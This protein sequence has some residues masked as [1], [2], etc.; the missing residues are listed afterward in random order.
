[1]IRDAVVLAAGEGRRL[2]PLTDRW[3]KPVLPLD[4]RP[5]IASLLHE[6]AAAGIERATVVTS[7][8]AD[9]IERLVGTA[10]AFPLEVRIARQPAPNG[11]AGAAL[12]G[13]AAGA[14]PPAI[15]IAADTVFTPG[16]LARFAEAFAASDASGAVAGRRDPPPAPPHRYALRVERGRVTRIFDDDPA[17]SLAAAP[18]WALRTPLV[19]LL[20][21][22][23]APFELGRAF[24]RA[25]D[26]GMTVL[27]V[28]IGRTRDL[29]GPVDLIEENFPYLRGL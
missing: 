1:V 9:A 14:E 11:S 28:E 19:P 18:L 3:P 16:D 24:Q 4:G 23:S 29:T 8:G 20:G 15:L 13:L 6:L 5:V 27:G 21:L 12:A 25:V 7:Y 2:R 10:G 22:D 17:N 26:A